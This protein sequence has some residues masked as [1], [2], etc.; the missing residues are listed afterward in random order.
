MF[1][2]TVESR[3]DVLFFVLIE[4]DHTLFVRLALI[5]KGLELNS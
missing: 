1:L 3:Y 5:Q 2:V 4:A